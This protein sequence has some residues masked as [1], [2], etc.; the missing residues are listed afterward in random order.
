[1]TYADFIDKTTSEKT[2]LI[3]MDLGLAETGWYNY[4]PGVWAHKWSTT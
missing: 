3:E 2:V 4:S 1:M